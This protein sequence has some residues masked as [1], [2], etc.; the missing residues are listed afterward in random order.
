MAAA[1]ADDLFFL[2]AGEQGDGEE[3]DPHA[4]QH[5]AAE[6]KEHTIWWSKPSIF[7]LSII[8]R[9]NRNTL[10]MPNDDAM[11]IASIAANLLKGADEPKSGAMRSAKFIDTK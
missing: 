10:Q 4:P 7:T 9:T 6:A 2:G 11:Y 5:A 1:R 8:P 3:R